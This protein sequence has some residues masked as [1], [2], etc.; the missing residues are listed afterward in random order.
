MPIYNEVKAINAGINT[1]AEVLNF[2]SNVYVIATK[3]KKKRGEVWL[4]C[5]DFLNIKEAVDNHISSDIAIV[6]LKYSMVFDA[7]FEKEKCIDELIQ[8]SPLARHHYSEVA[9][10]FNAIYYLINKS[11]AMKK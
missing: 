10:Q 9:R 3:L 8:D 4:D 6:P 7:I 11:Y 5:D 2:N 1:I